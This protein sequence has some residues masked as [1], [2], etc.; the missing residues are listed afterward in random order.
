MLARTATLTP[1]YGIKFVDL[2]IQ[3][4]GSQT[5]NEKRVRAD[6]QGAQPDCRRL[7]FLRRGASRRAGDADLCR[8]LRAGCRVLRVLAIDRVLRQVLP[9]FNKTL[10]TSMDYFKYL[11]NPGGQ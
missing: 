2:I 11:Y 7:P 3:Q 10:S 5:I 8:C 9:Q 1:Q 4:I 6:D